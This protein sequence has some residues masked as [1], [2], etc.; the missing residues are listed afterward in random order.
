MIANLGLCALLFAAS[1]DKMDVVPVRPGDLQPYHGVLIASKSDTLV[2]CDAGSALRFLVRDKKSA[3][4]HPNREWDAF[5]SGDTAITRFTFLKQT[6]DSLLFLVTMEKGR[7]PGIYEHACIEM[8]DL[9]ATYIEERFTY[10][11]EWSRKGGGDGGD[12]R[13]SGGGAAG[14]LFSVGLIAIILLLVSLNA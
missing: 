1:P 9:K 4:K 13:G 7:E 14:F 8:R 2:N 10:A 3:S 6:G 11:D 5:R 12:G